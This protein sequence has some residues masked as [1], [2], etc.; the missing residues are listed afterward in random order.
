[1]SPAVSHISSQIW[2]VWKAAASPS[3]VSDGTLL[4]WFPDR[5]VDPD[6]WTGHIWSDHAHRGHFHEP[7]E[8]NESPTL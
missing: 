2:D 7:V 3:G 8:D 5:D 4:K 1:M 6:P